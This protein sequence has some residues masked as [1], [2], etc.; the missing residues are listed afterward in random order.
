[1]EPTSND[2]VRD[3]YDQSADAYSA[4]MDA[5]IEL[6]LYATFLS[7]LAAR[8][9]SLDG[10]VLDTS[11]G[12]GHMLEKLRTQY[13]PDRALLGVDLS[14]RMVAIAQKRLGDA[15]TVVVG[16]MRALPHIADNTCAALINFFALH[17]VDRDGVRTCFAE[18][19]RVLTTGGHLLVAAWEGEGHIDYGEDAPIVALN[20]NAD[21]VSAAARAAGF[22]VDGCTV[23]PV[24]EMGIDAVY[25]TATKPIA[26]D[27]SAIVT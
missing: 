7:G 21:E 22:Q 15:A 11:C 19:H 12:S 25:L 16:D 20:H 4:M 14:P 8:I 26:S 27:S 17:H 3:F 5:E 23:E 13:A 1:M 10:P 24:E 18:W 2:K 9:A 6:P